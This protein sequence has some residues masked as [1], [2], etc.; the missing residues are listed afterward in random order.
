MHPA[1]SNG[2]YDV[3]RIRQDFPILSMQVYGKPLVTTD[4]GLHGPEI[5][6]LR[7]GENGI[8]TDNQVE[9]YATTVATLLSDRV[10]LARMRQTCLLD[11]A[12]YSLDNMAVRFVDGMVRAVA[13][14]RRS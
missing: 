9:P 2:S 4:C 11:A 13:A 3:A 1:V 12:E 7:N 10:A 6:Y 5:A 14:P 8:M